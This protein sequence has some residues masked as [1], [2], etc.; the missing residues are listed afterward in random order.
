MRPLGRGQVMISLPR[1]PWGPRASSASPA[2]SASCP[3]SWS[4]LHHADATPAP[5][6]LREP[7]FLSLAFLPWQAFS[8]F[9]MH[10]N[11]P[12]SLSKIAGCFF[13]VFI[14]QV[15]SGAREV[16]FPMSFQVMRKLQVWDSHCWDPLLLWCP[17]NTHSLDKDKVLPL[18]YKAMAWPLPSSRSV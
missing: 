5:L 3:F 8:S 2:P 9:G 12:E 16:A 13:L 4:W 6:T 1:A 11:L 7:S 14:Q 18:N 15:C 10:R 17:T